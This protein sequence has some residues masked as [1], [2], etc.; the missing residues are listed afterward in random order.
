AAAVCTVIAALL[1][2]FITAGVTTPLTA[3]TQASEAIAAGDYHRQVD[4]SRRDELGRLG[5]AFNAMA[6]Q[7]EAMRHDLEAQVQQRTAR[8][9]EAMQQLETVNGELEAFSYSVSHDLRAPLRHVTGFASLLEQRASPS[10]DP[11]ARRYVTTIVDAANRMGRLIDDLLA[12]SRIG[13]TPLA[14]RD[15]DLAAAVEEAQRDAAAAA[16]GRRVEWTI[17]A[18]PRV[19]ADP[20]L[21][22]Q[23]LLNLLSNAVKY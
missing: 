4:S 14:L 17:D 8:L 13:R 20:A 22:R 19:Q 3:L 16:N 7:G 10:L 1:T 21:L 18:L 11:E 9:T 12:F 2:A 5:A 23:V 15:V 6:R